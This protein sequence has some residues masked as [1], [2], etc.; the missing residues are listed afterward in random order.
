MIKN[1]FFILIFMTFSKNVF[2]AACDGINSDPE[3]VFSSSYGNLQYDT[4][5]NMTYIS[6]LAQQYGQKEAGFLAGGL[7]ISTIK[8]SVKFNG[9]AQYLNEN[10]ICIIPLKLEVFIGYSDPTIY[11]ANHLQPDTCKYYITVRHEQA[12]MQINKK[13]LEYFLPLFKQELHKIAKS[14]PPLNIDDSMHIDQGNQY[15]NQQYYDKIQEL[16]VIFNQNLMTEQSKLDSQIN[17]D[18]ESKLCSKF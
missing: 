3:V 13:T 10:D 14:I 17:Y 6:N 12:H 5:K 15:I 2:A 11:I 4:S 18:N 16:L 9:V 8:M 1:L 7:A